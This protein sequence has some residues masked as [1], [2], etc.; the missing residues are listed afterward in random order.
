MATFLHKS[1]V[2]L[3]A[4]ASLSL[5]LSPLALLAGTQLTGLEE[6]SSSK[7]NIPSEVS[8]VGYCRGRAGERRVPALT[9][10]G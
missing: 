6:H 7:L 8:L 3:S 10:Q 1:S 2:K 9:C 4:A 5:W